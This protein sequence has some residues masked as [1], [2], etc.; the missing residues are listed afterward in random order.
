MI[1]IIIGWKIIQMYIVLY[2]ILLDRTNSSLNFTTN[3]NSKKFDTVCFCLTI[4]NI[5]QIT[6][7]FVW[8]LWATN[9]LLNWICHGKMC[10][11]AWKFIQDYIF[12]NYN[13]QNTQY[14]KTVIS[15]LIVIRRKDNIFITCKN[16]KS[17][18]ITVIF[19]LIIVIWN[20]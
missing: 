1:I 18:L 15:E 2:R 5:S 20:L 7:K 16:V 4:P 12:Q 9:Y 10:Q 17:D 11:V 13:I 19:T 14:K 3:D 6:C 8:N